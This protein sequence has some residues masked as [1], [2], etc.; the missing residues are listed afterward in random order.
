MCNEN[1]VVIDTPLAVCIFK[2]EAHLHSEVSAGEEPRKRRRAG[3]RRWSR[4]SDRMSGGERR[5]F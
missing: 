1:K 4:L 2:D 5:R 3:G